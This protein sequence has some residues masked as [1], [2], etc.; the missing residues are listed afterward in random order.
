MPSTMDVFGDVV[1]AVGVDMDVDAEVKGPVHT[2]LARGASGPELRAI[3]L[4]CDGRGII[5]WGNKTGSRQSKA[6]PDHNL[7]EWP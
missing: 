5:L 3:F 6:R 7:W 2:R 4:L 1:V